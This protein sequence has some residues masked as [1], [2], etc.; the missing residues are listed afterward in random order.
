MSD[1]SRL[2]FRL[3]LRWRL[4][5]PLTTVLSLGAC[6]DGL[7]DCY[8]LA[9]TGSIRV[10]VIAPYRVGGEYAYDPDHLGARFSSSDDPLC[11]SLGD[12]DAGDALVLTGIEPLVIRANECTEFTPTDITLPPTSLLTIPQY[13]GPLGDN[14]NFD[15][16]HEASLASYANVERPSTSS[17]CH[18]GWWLY[19]VPLGVK[20]G[21]A[22]TSTATPGELPPWLLVRRFA[23]YWCTP[24]YERIECV[25]AWVAEVSYD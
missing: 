7:G 15:L 20:A 25:E 16:D 21:A 5:A 24:E 23:S 13:L 18:G 9:A 12:L 4:L 22:T 19:L 14:D 2:P 1:S 8:D 6:A 11:L 3:P 17:S 10:R